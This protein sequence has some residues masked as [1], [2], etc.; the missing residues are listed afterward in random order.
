LDI[1]HA[2]DRPEIPPPTI[3]ICFFLSGIYN[4]LSILNF[5]RIGFCMDRKQEI[6]SFLLE[7]RDTIVGSFEALEPSA[8][9]E[10]SRWDHHAGGHG[11]MSILRG[12]V[13]EK[14]AVDWSGVSGA[15]FPGPMAVAHFLQR[16]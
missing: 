12:E 15:Q 16:E 10:R 3:S 11:E 1:Y 9:F 6:I 5:F 14:A 13:F 2:A 8:K 4:H 7:L